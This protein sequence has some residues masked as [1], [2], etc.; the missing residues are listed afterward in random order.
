[1]ACTTDILSAAYSGLRSGAYSAYGGR[2]YA[3]VPSTAN[4]AM[5]C[6]GTRNTATCPAVVGNTQMRGLIGIVYTSRTI[7]FVL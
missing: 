5:P 6:M 3:E 4:A 1:M 2:Q 7:L